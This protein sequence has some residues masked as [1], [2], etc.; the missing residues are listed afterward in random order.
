MA[1]GNLPQALSHAGPIDAAGALR[2]AD[3]ARA[4]L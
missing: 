1:L 2:R 4:A 3:R